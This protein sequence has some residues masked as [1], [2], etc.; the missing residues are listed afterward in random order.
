[1]K[2]LIRKY[3]PADLRAAIN[4]TI[5]SAD[6][7]LVRICS[8][9]NMLSGIYYLFFSGKF[10]RE[11]RAVLKGR[12]AYRE[13]LREIGRTCAL[14][15]RNVHR[16]EKGLIMRPRRATFAEGYINE[17][18]EIYLKAARS[19][20]L[21]TDE[22]KWA[23]DVIEEYFSVVEDTPVIAKARDIFNRFRALGEDETD[24]GGE[25]N[26]FDCYKPYP[27]KEIEQSAVTYD[28]LAM[29]FRQRRSVRWYQDKSIPSDLIQK[30]IDIASLAPSACNRQPYEFIVCSDKSRAVEIAKCA[31][32]TVGFAENLQSIIVVTGNLSFFPYER[33]R[34]LIYIDASLATMQL[35][36]ALES[37]GLSTCPINWPDVNQSENRMKRIIELPHYLRVVLLLAVGYADMSGGVAYS[38]KKSAD[39]LAQTDP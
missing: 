7:L 15:R 29:L 30:A 39:I 24:T 9:T 16:L 3:V 25:C 11:H 8:S 12:L 35:M 33:D 32:G 6:L 31:G 1:M 34:H 28:Q 22:Q 14:L 36:L 23:R 26:V 5:E 17:T 13:S 4:K 2:N 38:Q 21:S 10:D 20:E 37:L 18:V 27:Y 19:R